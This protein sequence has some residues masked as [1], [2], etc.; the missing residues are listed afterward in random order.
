MENN[1]YEINKTYNISSYPKL[2][3]CLLGA[4]SLTKH[5]DINP[6]KHSEYGIGFDRKGPFLVG[7]GFGR[8]CIIFGVDMS[9][10]VHVDNKKKDII[11]LGEGLTQGLDCTT[12]IAEKLYS[13]NFT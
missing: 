11:I 5:V 1:K 4:V 7:N 13:I 3:N 8:N 6:Y 9:S 2:E 12:L 10:S